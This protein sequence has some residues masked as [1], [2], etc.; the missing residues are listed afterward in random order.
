MYREA[1]D[2][3]ALKSDWIKVQSPASMDD[4]IKAENAIG[5]SFPNDLKQLLLELNGDKYLFLSTAEIIETTTIL[6]K[7][8][9]EYEN[10]TQHIFFATNGCRDYYCYNL[11]E[12]GVADGEKI[13]CWDHET[14]ETHIVASSILELIER[15]YND[16]I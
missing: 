9:S 1:I 14:N 12:N 6:P 10:I 11:D 5:Y 15:Y 7:D 13:Y 8:L 3:G 4:I 16:E 2:H